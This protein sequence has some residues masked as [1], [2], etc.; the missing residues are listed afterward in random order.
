[1]GETLDIVIFSSPMSRRGRR[2]RLAPD[3]AMRT[4]SGALLDAEARRLR[5]RD[6][7]VVAFQPDDEVLAVMGLNAMD[8]SRRAAIATAAYDATRHRLDGVALRQ[9]L[10]ALRV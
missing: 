8:P 6:V 9:R 2:P 3:Q 10:A 1:V 4:W 5:R 7:D